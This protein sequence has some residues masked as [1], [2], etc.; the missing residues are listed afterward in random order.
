MCYES[1]ERLL[2]AR[3]QRRAADEPAAPGREAP[4]PD[5]QKSPV[6]PVTQVEAPIR[7]REPA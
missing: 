6:E 7:Q 1:Y 4:K 5:T 2:R 3:A